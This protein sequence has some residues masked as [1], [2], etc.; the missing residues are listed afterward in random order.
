MKIITISKFYTEIIFNFCIIF[1]F[2]F[3][4]YFSFF[5][6]CII[7]R[8]FFVFDFSIFFI[9]QF[10]KLSFCIL[11]KHWHCIHDTT[12]VPI[13]LDRKK[14]QKCLFILVKNVN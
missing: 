3:L 7:F 4:Y 2:R 8:F 12:S 1:S 6:V 10:I 13:F 11:P 5:S 14:H 9:Y